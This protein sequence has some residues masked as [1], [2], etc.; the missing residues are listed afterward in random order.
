MKLLLIGILFSILLFCPA[1]PAQVLTADHVPAAVRQAMQTKFPDAKS[2]EWKL[3]PEVILRAAP[4][5]MNQPGTF[6]CR[7]KSLLWA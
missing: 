7:D 6:S 2:A 3:K 4:E 1:S 5:P